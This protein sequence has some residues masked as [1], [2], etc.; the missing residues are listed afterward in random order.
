MERIKIEDLKNGNETYE[1]GQCSKSKRPPKSS[2]RRETKQKI[3]RAQAEAMQAAWNYHSRFP[4][5]IKKK[6]DRMEK[7]VKR[8]RRGTPNEELKEEYV[9]WIPDTGFSRSRDSKV[10]RMI[11]LYW[12]NKSFIA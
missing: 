5:D 12:T 4:E 2:R 7:K 6:I 11:K 3:T 1:K 10:L 8:K 9:N